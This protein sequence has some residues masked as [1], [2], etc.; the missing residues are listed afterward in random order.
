[1]VVV[2]GLPLEDM[3]SR[4]FLTK[5][6]ERGNMKRARV[7]EL[8]N[9]FDDDLEVEPTRCEFNIAFE[10]NDSGF[11]D[12]MSYDDI[13]YFVKKEYNNEDGHIWKFRKILSHSLISGKKGVEDKIEV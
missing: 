2:V 1:M 4:V 13:L 11:K 3:V 6:D 9:K 12:I 10:D 5:P 8:I 7:I